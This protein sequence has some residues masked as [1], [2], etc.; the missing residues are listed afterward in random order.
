MGET[1]KRKEFSTQEKMDILAQVNANKETHDVL[2]TR[3]G[4]VPSTLT[5]IFTN[6][7]DNEKCYAQ[8]GRFF[9]QGKSLQQSSFKKLGSLL[10]KWFKHPRGNNAVI[11]GTLLTEEALLIYTKLGIEDYKASN[12]W[13]N[14]FKQ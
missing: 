11:S 12:G 14:N 8:C 6:R 5:T 4:T 7:K 3:L 13:I 2:A 9:G 10:A 1:K